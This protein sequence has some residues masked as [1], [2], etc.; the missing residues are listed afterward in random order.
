M[1][2]TP[3]SCCALCQISNVD[4]NTTKEEL[5][6]QLVILKEEASETYIPGDN[7]KKGQTS[8]FVVTSPGEDKLEE[9]LQELH[10]SPVHTFDR[11]KG[12]KPGELT[13]FIKN[14]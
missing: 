10:F 8:V 2:K 4:N 13:I 7:S 5:E 9:L 12:Y 3:T 6:A 1:K 14:L 11:R